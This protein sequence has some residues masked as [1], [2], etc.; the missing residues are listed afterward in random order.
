MLRLGVLFS[1]EGTGDLKYLGC[2]KVGTGPRLGRRDRGAQ[3]GIGEVYRETFSQPAVVFVGI[4]NRISKY[5]RYIVAKIKYALGL[6]AQRHCIEC[7]ANPKHGGG[8]H[9]PSGTRQGRRG[10]ARPTFDGQGAFASV[11]RADAP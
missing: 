10:C 9:L 4:V 5:S 6:F 2:A 7:S 1:L 11:L 3:G 8:K